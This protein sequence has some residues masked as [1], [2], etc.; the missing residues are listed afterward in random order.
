LLGALFR[1]KKKTKVKTNLMVF[2]KP[3]ILYNQSDSYTL[4][5]N[6]YKYLMSRNKKASKDRVEVL[7][8][9]KPI[10][11]QPEPKAQP[12]APETGVKS[13]PKTEE[14][15]GPPNLQDAGNAVQ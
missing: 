5:S 14:K 11:P 1:Y 7:E 2:L 13:E 4:S 3:T 10:E 12:P 8:A 15:L 9:F 6:R